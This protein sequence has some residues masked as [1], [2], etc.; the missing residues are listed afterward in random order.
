M[1]KRITI[2]CIIN[3]IAITS[4][5]QVQLWG[6][7]SAGG[8]NSYG[9]VFQYEATTN[10]FSNEFDFKFDGV[11]GFNPTGSLLQASNGM[12]Y[13]M[14]LQGGLNN[15]GILFEYNSNTHIYTKRVDFSGTI[16]SA[17]YGSL[18]QCSDGN[19]YGM[20]SQ[21]G[22]NGKGV[23]FKYDPSLNIY[24]KLFDFDGAL[25]GNYP[26]AA[27]L[28]ASD[29]NL[30][31]MTKYGGANGEGV[32]FQYNPITD[33][34]I[35]KLD[36]SAFS[37]GSNP[38]GSLMQALDGKLYGLCSAGGSYAG[39]TGGGTLFQYDQLL[40]S[41]VKKIDF[42]GTTFGKQPLG[43]LMQASDSM[44]Y[45]MTRDGGSYN[46]GILFQYNLSN[47]IC[48]NKINFNGASRGET[49]SSSLMQAS[50]GLLYGMVQYGG[51]NGKGVLFQ[52]EP[53]TSTFTKKIDLSTTL[54]SNPY[55]T[56][57]IEVNTS[58]VGIKSISVENDINVYPNPNNGIFIIQSVNESAY[59]IV[60][61]LG[62]TIQ[63]INL[64]ARNN[65]S[66]TTSGLKTGIYF[67]IGLNNNTVITRKIVV[68]N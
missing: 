60:N 8:T 24:T 9:N 6:M 31:G 12:L 27:L 43:S 17:P 50:D 26:N 56:H 2:S 21:G 46:K 61:E 53:A 3:L 57:F 23:L 66:S 4:H 11:L 35:N 16:G 10:S 63:S 22:L 42:D 25:H 39:T 14:T 30:Y 64:N 54:G 40:N 32:L 67:I 55:F 37:T 1:K 47:G 51:L 28:Q 48:I 41:F 20:T 33:T 18:I 49:P 65:F 62:Q 45:G 5:A 15:A 13:G 29:G 68:V 19:L 58:T 44:L 7:T 52:Y 38:F 34:L 36:F 59:K